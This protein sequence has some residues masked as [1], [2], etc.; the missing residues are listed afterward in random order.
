MLR[1]ALREAAALI[2]ALACNPPLAPRREVP[3]YKAAL[4]EALALPRGAQQRPQARLRS[5]STLRGP[6]GGDATPLFGERTARPPVAASA[7]MAT[8]RPQLAP[9]ADK[10][11]ADLSCRR[12]RSAT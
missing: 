1:S 4:R 11:V 12:R 2:E 10:R 8:Y 7:R 9:M 3:A 5:C 6:T